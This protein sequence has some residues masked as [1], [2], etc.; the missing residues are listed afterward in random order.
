M[1]IVNHRR[2]RTAGIAVLSAALTLGCAPARPQ[3]DVQAQSQ[4]LRADAPGAPLPEALRRLAD[5]EARVDFLLLGEIHDHP[6]HHRLRIDWLEAI[7]PRWRFALAMEQFDADRQGDIDRARAQRA[8]ARE[9]AQA[10]GFDFRGWD[11][12]H[13]APFVELALRF[14]LPLVAANLSAREARAIA[15]GGAHP[16]A[17]VEP[18]GWTGE[19]AQRMAGDLQRGHCGMLPASALP[20]MSAAQRARDATI[21]RAIVDAQRASGLPVVLL[22]GNGHVRRDLGVPR[23]LSGL[24]PQATVLAVGLIERDDAAPE[25]APARPLQAFDLVVETPAH[26]RPDPCEAFRTRRG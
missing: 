3:P 13:Y 8:S 22:T 21:A 14:D 10:A 23:Y 19:D 26:P 18:P 11:W 4:A 25:Q 9:I 24:A 12:T 20:A 7:A 15:R 2:M 6:L 1:G 5:G 17:Q 16:M